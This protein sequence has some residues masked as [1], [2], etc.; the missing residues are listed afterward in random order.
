MADPRP[1]LERVILSRDEPRLRAGWR[2]SLQWTIAFGLGLCFSL[3][4]VF[5]PGVLTAGRIPMEAM[6]ASALAGAVATTISVVLARRFF[7]RRTFLSLGLALDRRTLLDLGVG[8]VIPAFQ[9]GLVFVLESS[10][11]W[12]RWEGWAWEAEPSSSVAV[13]LGIGLLTFILV[14]YQEELQFRGYQLQTLRD[15]SGLRWAVV[16][17][18]AV[19]SLA[20]LANPGTGLASTIGLFFAGCF[21]AFGW[22]RTRA[23][24]L[25][26]GLHIGWNFFEGTFFGFAV[27][28]L[29][30]ETLMRHTVDGPA[31]A[32]GGAFG[33]EAGL[34]M[35]PAY[36]LGLLL[37]AAYT[38]NRPRTAS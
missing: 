38:R 6:F 2:A 26:I 29:D 24:W 23:L 28:G 3:P 10:L 16:I 1:I 37:I 8:F 17:S 11:G 32:T 34:V 12:I 5:L 7:D 4:V 25:S 14:G 30:L 9:M 21:L 35:L 20:H 19:F 27:S 31:W 22:I 33:P 36:A 13:G 18:S 15:G